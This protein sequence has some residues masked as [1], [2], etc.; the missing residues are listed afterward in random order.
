MFEN[1]HSFDQ[2]I[3]KWDMTIIENKDDMFKNSLIEFKRDHKPKLTKVLDELV[4]VYPD[5][6]IKNYETFFISKNYTPC[7]TTFLPFFLRTLLPLFIFLSFIFL[8]YLLMIEISIITRIDITVK[9]PKTNNIVLL[10]LFT[11]HNTIVVTS[12]TIN[13]INDTIANT[14]KHSIGTIYEYM[15]IL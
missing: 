10:Q 3:D 2:S 6:F 13:T 5:I 9:D 4:E 11:K 14:I 7:N 1:T 15:L 8:I 12:D